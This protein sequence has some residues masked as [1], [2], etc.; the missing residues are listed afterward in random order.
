MTYVMKK[1]D[2]LQCIE[3]LWTQSTNIDSGDIHGVNFT[4][5]ISIQVEDNTNR[6]GPI[7][8]FGENYST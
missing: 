3:E 6:L 4:K 1:E 5:E 7:G 8:L 2:N